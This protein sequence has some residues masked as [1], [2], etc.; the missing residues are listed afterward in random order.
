MPDNLTIKDGWLVGPWRQAINDFTPETRPILRTLFQNPN[1][2]LNL[3]IENVEKD[4]IT[5]HNDEVAQKVG[6]RGGVVA[7]I[8]HLDL[9]A[10]LMQNLFGLKVFETGSLSLYYT[11]ALLDREEVRA[12]I[13]VPPK[14]L[15]DVQVEVRADTLEGRIV[16]QGTLAVGHPMEKSYLQALEL[17]NSPPDQLRILKGIQAGDKM[18]PFEELLD[19]TA[20][21]NWLV[22]LEDTIDWYSQKSPW[23]PPIAPLS[24]II[25]FMQVTLPFLPKA[26]GFFG[27]TEI[28][29]FNGPIKTG[30]PYRAEGEIVAVGATTKTE[31]YWFE[32][33]LYDK[34]T[35]KPVAGMRH[36]TRF[37][38]AGSPLYPEL[39]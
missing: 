18:T 4:H 17:E 39:S 11:Y 32:S 25:N 27:G 9:F 3:Q 23:G 33:R 12:V 15:D 14:G 20:L 28:Q 8:Q 34:G 38:K 5:I 31:F 36:M 21:E 22:F 35:G 37:M 13:Q 7:G 10:P 26:V 2:P 1:N 19:G 24:R 16:A 29:F 6:M 30:V